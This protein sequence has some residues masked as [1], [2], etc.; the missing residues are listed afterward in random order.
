VR[1]DTSEGIRERKLRR[2]ST[3][4]ASLPLSTGICVEEG[5]NRVCKCRH[6]RRQVLEGAL[7]HPQ[8]IF[9]ERR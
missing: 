8:E 7:S 2:F 9:E 6:R 1:V 3:F 5:L 4:V